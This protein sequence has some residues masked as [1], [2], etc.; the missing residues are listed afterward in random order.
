[1]PASSVESPRHATAGETVVM[2]ATGSA[3]PCMSYLHVT[4]DLGGIPRLRANFSCD[5]NCQPDR[6]VG[7]KT[8]W[9]TCFAFTSITAGFL[10]RASA[11]SPLRVSPRTILNN[12]SAVDTQTAVL[13]STAEVW[14][15]APNT[16]TTIFL[17]FLGIH[18]DEGRVD[19]EAAGQHDDTSEYTLTPDRSR[20]LRSSHL[21][22][23]K[24]RRVRMMSQASGLHDPR[25]DVPP[26]RNLV[27]RRS[28]GPGLMKNHP[29]LQ[30]F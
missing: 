10:Y 24:G 17:G 18:S 23:D 14:I 29:P 19:G 15:S 27:P 2:D 30:I 11:E 1:M 6:T 22:I 28:W 3:I 25:D 12:L 20:L 21:G 5:S 9:T 13:V 16:Q 7:R 8:P 26:A 4:L